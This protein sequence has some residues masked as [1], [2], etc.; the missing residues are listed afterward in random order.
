MPTPDDGMVLVHRLVPQASPLA[1]SKKL[2]LYTWMYRRWEMIDP[3]SVDVAC[4]SVAST[5][6]ATFF[7][8]YTLFSQ[9]S[10]PALRLELCNSVYHGVVGAA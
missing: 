6:P 9:A 3:Q 1:T 4:V 5:T 8:V 2:M 10:A 7:S